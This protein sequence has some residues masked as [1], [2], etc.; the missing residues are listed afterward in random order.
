M[1]IKKGTITPRYYEAFKAGA[2]KMV[3]EQ[4]RPSKEVASELGICI[5]TI[6]SWIKRAGFQPS[7]TDRQNRSDKRQREL[8]AEIRSLCKLLAEKVVKNTLW[9]DLT[10]LCI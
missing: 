4:G 2:V 5:N 3:T 9:Q 6:K 7:A 8:E 1:S 10:P